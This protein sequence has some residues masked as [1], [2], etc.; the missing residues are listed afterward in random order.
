MTTKRDIAK[1]VVGTVAKYGTGIIIYSV[2]RN[3]VAAERLDQKVGVA[4]A[5]FVLASM[6]AE[7]AEKYTDKTVDEIFDAFE[8]KKVHN[9]TTCQ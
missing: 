1:K 9:I 6:V 7:A 8:G 3:E 4:V 5:S 2:V